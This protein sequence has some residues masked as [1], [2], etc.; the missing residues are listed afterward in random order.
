M[1]CFLFFIDIIWSYVFH[2]INITWCFVDYR[3]H[4]EEVGTQDG[5]AVN[6]QLDAW[7]AHKTETGVVYYYN[8]LTGQSTYDKPPGFKGEVFTLRFAFF[9]Y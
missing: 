7:T 4:V 3:K 6:E 8:A 1:N 5:A 9:K 2:F